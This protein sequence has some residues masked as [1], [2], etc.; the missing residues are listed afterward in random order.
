MPGRRPD[1]EPTLAEIRRKCE[2]IQSR[3][4]DKERRKRAGGWED[5]HW[6]PPRVDLDTPLLDDPAAHSPS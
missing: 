6:M 5:P 3:W 2:E 1:Y 4:S